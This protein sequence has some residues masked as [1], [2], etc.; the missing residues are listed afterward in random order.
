MEDV[1]SKFGTTAV[2]A[3][4]VAA[5]VTGV[6]IGNLLR[7][8]ES[9]PPATARGNQPMFENYCHGEP[10]QL[11]EARRKFP[12][13]VLV[14][15]HAQA[16]EENLQRVWRCPGIAL[17]MEFA[18]GIRVTL[19]DRQFAD[20]AVAWA[21]LAKQ[22]APQS[23]VEMVRG[24]PALVADPSKDPTG[25]T[26]GLVEFIV[27]DLQVLVVGDGEIPAS[28]LREVAESLSE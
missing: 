16:S 13:R 21:Q 14:P 20:P 6:V 17:T 27:G 22:Y 28:T 25:N 7:T 15:H 1:N 9:L 4:L 2:G 19:E 3:I 18:S 11:D 23:S 8:E 26:D 24:V 5:A 10:W 12:R